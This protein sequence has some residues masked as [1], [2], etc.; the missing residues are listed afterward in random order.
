MVPRH[1]GVA[2]TELLPISPRTNRV[3]SAVFLRPCPDSIRVTPASEMQ[4]CRYSRRRFLV[5]VAGTAVGLAA[6]PVFGRS[7]DLTSLTLKEASDLFRRKTASP[8]TPRM[9]GVLS[10]ETPLGRVDQPEEPARAA[11]W[12][13]LVNLLAATTSHLVCDAGFSRRHPSAYEIHS[14]RT[15]AAP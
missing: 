1:P 9:R 4:Q 14:F 13:L 11:A 6:K 12:L 7:Q 3:L 8:V 10:K 2:R 5:A 15:T